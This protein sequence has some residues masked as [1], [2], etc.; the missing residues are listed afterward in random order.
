MPLLKT[1]TGKEYVCNFMGV[2]NGLVLY[3]QIAIDL[4]EAITIFTNPDET[5]T[6]SWYD[7]QGLLIETEHGFT[8][9]GGIFIEGGQCPIQI[10]LLKKLEVD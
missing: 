9:F 4:Q 10:R 6:L 2:A 7:L 5:N 8:E 3:I 1:A